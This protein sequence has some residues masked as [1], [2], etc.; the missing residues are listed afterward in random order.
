MGVVCRFPTA[1][2]IISDTHGM[3]VDEAL[4]KLYQQE[5]KLLQLGNMESAEKIKD[6]IVDIQYQIKTNL[7][8]ITLNGIYFDI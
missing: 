4:R 1:E 5:L 8:T 3:R 2:K 7:E 6:F